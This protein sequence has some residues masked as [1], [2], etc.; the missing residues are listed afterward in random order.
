M[1]SKRRT[2]HKC[3]PF[4]HTD[5]P[6][7]GEKDIWDD[8]PNLSPMDTSAEQDTGSRLPRVVSPQKELATI[9]AIEGGCSSLV[10]YSASSIKRGIPEPMDIE[11]VDTTST[12][13]KQ[14]VE[15]G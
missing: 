12:P 13:K 7:L 6:R 15:P 10:S 2:T 5:I 8:F 1:I 14:K 9:V 11:E 4:E 3:H